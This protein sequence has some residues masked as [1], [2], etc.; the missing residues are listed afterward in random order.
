MVVRASEQGTNQR[1]VR[2]PPSSVDENFDD[3]LDG[4]L[5]MPDREGA[6]SLDVPSQRR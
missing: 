5:R 1:V 6:G 4:W 3:G 2:Q